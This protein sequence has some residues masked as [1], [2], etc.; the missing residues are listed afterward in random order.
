VRVDAI[1]PTTGRLSLRRAVTSVLAQTVKVTP[2]VV[3][4]RPDSTSAVKE[5]LRGL[6]H[7]LVLTTGNQGASA[8]RNLGVRVSDADF[9][10]FLDDDDEWLPEK[11]EEQLKKL[12]AEDREAIVSRAFLVGRGCRIV[13]EFTYKNEVEISTYLIERS[14]LRLRRNYIQSSSLILSKSVA[15]SHQWDESLPRHEDWELFIRLRQNGIELSVHETPLVRVNQGSPGS[16]SMSDDWRA[17]VDWLEKYGDMASGQARADFVWSV[18]IR[19]AI[20]ARDWSGAITS[21]RDLGWKRPH[22]A[23]VIVGLS[24][25]ARRA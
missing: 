21:A 2:I 22:L 19:S 24:A 16:L 15:K 9:L 6:E 1:I 4:D 18:V 13:P 23:A 12:A 14:T 5:I 17:S 8:A 3:L 11:T 7:H 20:A 25:L 10:A